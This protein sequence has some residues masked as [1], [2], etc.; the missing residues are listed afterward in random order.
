MQALR[1]LWRDRTGATAVEYCFIATIVSLA[2]IVAFRAIGLSLTDILT[3]VTN[4][5]GGA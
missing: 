3:A 5:M 1:V 2:A 4:G